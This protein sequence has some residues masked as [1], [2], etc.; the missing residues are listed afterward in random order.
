MLYRRL[1]KTGELLLRGNKISMFGSSIVRSVLRAH[2]VKGSSI[3]FLG[4]L[5]RITA[6]VDL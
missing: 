4:P 6:Y 5:N 3:T 1:L 2:S